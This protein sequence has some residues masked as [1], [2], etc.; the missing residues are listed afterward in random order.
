MKFCPKCGFHDPDYWRTRTHPKRFYVD[1]CPI[2]VLR[3]FE[4]KLVEKIENS[5]LHHN[6]YYEGQ[7]VYTIKHQNIERIDNHYTRRLEH[8]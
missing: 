1:Y 3:Q 2:D 8:I 5:P 4:P 7:Y 6:V